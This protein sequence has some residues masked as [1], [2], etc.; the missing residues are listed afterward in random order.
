MPLTIVAGEPAVPSCSLLCR[1]GHIPESGLCRFTGC[2]RA[3]PEVPIGPADG[4]RP[5]CQFR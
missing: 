4:F 2:L 3:Q 1:H 5:G